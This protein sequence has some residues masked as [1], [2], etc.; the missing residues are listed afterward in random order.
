MKYPVMWHCRV[1]NGGHPSHQRPIVLPHREQTPSRLTV[2][3]HPPSKI[4]SCSSGKWRTITSRKGAMSFSGSIIAS[5]RRRSVLRSAGWS[6]PDRRP[7]RPLATISRASSRKS[8][9]RKGASGSGAVNRS[10][11]LSCADRP[12]QRDGMD[13]PA[14]GTAV[15]H[16]G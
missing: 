2:P 16:S 14:S 1:G 13:G 6:S 3:G 5:A 4:A 8:T 12:R 9:L 11:D 7:L 10:T 15:P